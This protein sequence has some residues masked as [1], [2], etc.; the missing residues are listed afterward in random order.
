MVGAAAA[1]I[2]SPWLMALGAAAAVFLLLHR[3][4]AS[5]AA[6]GVAAAER[7]VR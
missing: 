4:V 7:L 3:Q 1:W 5:P 6:V 2:V